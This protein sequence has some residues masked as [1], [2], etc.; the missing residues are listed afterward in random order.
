MRGCKDNKD[1]LREFSVE[2]EVNLEIKEAI[3]DDELVNL[4]NQATMVV[5]VPLMEPF[6]FIPLEAMAC[7]TPVIGIR[8]AGVRE[9]IGDGQ[10]GI[11]I[12]RDPVELA[13]AIELL[14]SDKSLVEAL[15]KR[16]FEDV[17]KNWTWEKA[18][19]RL[20]K[21]LI[22]VIGKNRNG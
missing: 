20:E 1:F 4:Y 10:T 5:F 14:L 11:L 15:R 21:N 19:D 16:G 12:D 22:E 3:S 7:G 13:Q 6:G 17:N 9:S 18:T 8:E 2:K